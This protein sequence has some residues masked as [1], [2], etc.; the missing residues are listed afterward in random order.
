MG[1]EY[2]DDQEIIL[3]NGKNSHSRF[4]RCMTIIFLVEW[5]LFREKI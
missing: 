3:F 2:L 1:N 4:L 5:S